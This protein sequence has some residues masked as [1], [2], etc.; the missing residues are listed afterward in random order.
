[1]HHVYYTFYRALVSLTNA[2]SIWANRP[3]IYLFLIYYRSF[4]DLSNLMRYKKTDGHFKHKAWNFVFF[5][6]VKGKNFTLAHFPLS[7]RFWLIL[8]L[9]HTQIHTQKSTCSASSNYP[10]NFLSTII[11]FMFDLESCLFKTLLGKNWLS[12]A[13]LTG[14]PRIHLLTVQAF[15]PFHSFSFTNPSQITLSCGKIGMSQN[16]LTDDFK[17]CSWTRCIRGRMS[18]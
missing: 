13:I 15:Y 10:L 7:G 1:V 8:E 5:M 9:F 12:G 18:S 3:P 4:Y 11:K 14:P 2:L 16:N 6:T 17:R